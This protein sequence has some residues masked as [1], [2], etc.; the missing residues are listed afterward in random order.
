MNIMVLRYDFHM[1]LRWLPILFLGLGTLQAQNVT[2]D[3][4]E[5]VDFSKFK[6]YS[7]RKAKA[8]KKADPVDNSISDNRIRTSIAAQLAKKGFTEAESG[9]DVVITYRVT[10][11]DKKQTE[12]SPG[13][14][15]RG[16]FGNTTRVTSVYTQGTLLIDMLNGDNN[17]LIWRATCK[18]TVSDPEKFEKRLGQDVEKAFKKYPPKK[19]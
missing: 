7:W 15:R 12:R 17:E 8:A 14:G 5:A 19:K 2:T 9:G 11:K 6:T 3:F 13:M 18:D 10:S 16:G 1:T 4:N